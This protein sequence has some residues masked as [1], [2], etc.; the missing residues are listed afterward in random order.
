MNNNLILIGGCPRSGTTAL[1][2]TL[3]KNK[4]I[5]LF[6][7]YDLPS[8]IK[9]ISW[10][11]IKEKNIKRKSWIGNIDRTGDKTQVVGEY[12]N[13][14]PRKNDLPNLLLYIFTKGDCFAQNKQNQDFLLGEKYPRYWLLDY[15]SLKLNNFSSKLIIIFRNP[16]DV[17]LSYKHRQEITKKGLDEWSYNNKYSACRHWLETWILSKY[18]T[19]DHLNTLFVKYENIGLKDFQNSIESFLEIR[20]IDFTYFK[21]KINK[22]NVYKL[23][24]LNFTLFI[25]IWNNWEKLSIKELYKRYSRIYFLKLFIFYFMKNP[26][27]YFSEPRNN[28]LI[29]LLLFFPKLYLKLGRLKYTFYTLKTSLKIMLP[30]E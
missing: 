10:T 17:I 26:I 7:E 18:T 5:F 6:P 12:I 30:K 29:T 25:D 23:R 8:L 14:I 1:F 13:Y 27:D 3:V 2:S 9:S 15:K 22:K 16:L 24:D 20:D 11:Y 21:I 4:K 28:F 19:N